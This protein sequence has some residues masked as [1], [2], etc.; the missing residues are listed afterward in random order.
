MQ[1]CSR[2]GHGIAT[3]NPYCHGYGHGNHCYLPSTRPSTEYAIP[4]LPVDEL[5]QPPPTAPSE[6][7][8]PPEECL[9]AKVDTLTDIVGKLAMKIE[10][11]EKKMSAK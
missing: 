5:Q 11:F 6:P 1:H 3:H 10:E 7:P 2:C 9:A 4:P 8:V